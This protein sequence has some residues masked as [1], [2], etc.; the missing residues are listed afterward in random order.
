MVVRKVTK[1]GRS[2]SRLSNILPCNNFLDWSLLSR[3]SPL[4]WKGNKVS[5]LGKMTSGCSRFPMALNSGIKTQHA[6]KYGPG[7]NTF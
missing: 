4:N 3:N 7:T 1:S 5:V 2:H 6:V